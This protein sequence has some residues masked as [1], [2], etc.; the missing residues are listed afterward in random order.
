MSYEE[1]TK[2]AEAV[3]PPQ[4]NV[5]RREVEQYVAAFD[6]IDRH[7]EITQKG[8]F[9]KTIANPAGR[10][11][12]GLVA[13]KYN[14]DVLVGKIMS[15]EEDNF[16]LLCREKFA[17]DPTS[18][19]IFGLVREGMLGTASF[20][21][22]MP[23]ESIKKS[24]ANGRPVRILTEIDLWEAGPVDPDHAANPNTH[25]VSV[26]GLGEVAATVTALSK[27]SAAH[28]GCNEVL[29]S[30]TPEEID[31][32]R[33]MLAALPMATEALT[34][35]LESAGVKPLPETG[36]EHMAPGPEEVA[37]MLKSMGRK[38]FK[39]D[40]DYLLAR[41]SSRGR[42]VVAK[43]APL[44]SALL[45]G[46]PNAVPV[47][48][49]S[50]KQTSKA[51]PIP[52][53]KNP[54]E[55]EVDTS[56]DSGSEGEE[57]KVDKST[58]A[59][60]G[61]AAYKADGAVSAAFKASTAMQPGDRVLWNTS[62]NVLNTPSSEQTDI[63][64]ALIAMQS[65]VDGLFA[66]A[67]SKDKET[68]S[69]LKEMIDAAAPEDAQKEAPADAAVPAAPAPGGEVK[70][71]DPALVGKAEMPV[72]A[73]IATA[74]EDLSGGIQKAFEASQEAMPEQFAEWNDAVMVLGTP[75]TSQEE[76]DGALLKLQELLVM[77]S[78][79]I[80]AADKKAVKALSEMIDSAVN[81]ESA[82]GE[83]TDA[84]GDM[85]MGTKK[86]DQSAVD[87]IM[88]AEKEADLAIIA[89]FSASPDV[90]REQ[91]VEWDDAI[92]ILLS[93]DSSEAQRDESFMKMLEI[94]ALLIPALPEADVPM[95]TKLND[96]LTAASSAK[97]EIV[98][99]ES[100][101]TDAFMPPAAATSPVPVSASAKG[102]RLAS[103][104]LVQKF[105]AR[106]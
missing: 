50:Q 51:F 2:S 62:V 106:R 33:A 83:S 104:A 91:H 94:L 54:A 4:F 40:F 81:A 82:V 58:P 95:V 75:D 9:A 68:I 102:V 32:V 60:I 49:P 24:N 72:I 22:Y 26:K 30:L 71:G 105:S 41:A 1:I 16:G 44:S 13:L 28:D 10:L 37:Q 14:H 52:A 23:R 87:E 90:S 35:I 27:L 42:V 53:T 92:D 56:P 74:A 15:A 55:D 19:R 66:S 84:M 39:S 80:P 88:A 98:L 93:P 18:D 31:G 63:D 89:A 59:E 65:I 45:I 8:A 96:L 76:T 99:D 78:T 100:A 101:V 48:L 34:R 85:G 73:E 46:Y 86:A 64:K 69:S 6:S 57:A 11:Q 61:A 38:G 43:R 5:V 7:E 3:P 77:L 29:A 47:R 103:F 25:V 20:R 36:E 12:R 21:G 17:T 70:Q 79:S 67:T 97:E